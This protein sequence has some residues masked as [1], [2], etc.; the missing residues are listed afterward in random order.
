[1]PN[2]LTKEK[3]QSFEKGPIRRSLFDNGSV[4]LFYREKNRSCAS[5]C[6]YFLVGTKDE[7]KEEHGIVHFI[8]HMLFKEN[9]ADGLIDKLELAGASLN[10]YT[11]RE[12]VCFEMSCLAKRLDEF[13]PMFLELF[14]NPVFEKKAFETE[15][16]VILQEIKDEQDDHE[17][18]GYDKILNWHLD[19]KLGHSITGTLSSVKKITLDQMEKFY[20]KH[21]V[22]NKMI[23]SVVSGSEFSKLE[24]IFSSKQNQKKASR[25]QKPIRLK[26][27]NKVGKFTPFKK[28][29]KRKMENALYFLSF[30]GPSLSSQYFYDYLVLDDI[31]CEGLSSKYFKELREKR[32]LLYSYG[33]AINSFQNTGVYLQ[34]FSCQKDKVNSLK[35]SLASLLKSYSESSFSDEEVDFV[36]ARI[37]DHWQMEFDDIDDI[38]EFIA[39]KEIYGQTNFSLERQ[40]EKLDEV[41]KESLKA[42]LVKL[43]ATGPS[44][45]TYL[46]K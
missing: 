38:N 3:I 24:K 40:C 20:Q 6:L 43:L 18:L 30:D 46:P 42:L 36:K 44:E 28:Q 16:K 15:K 23:L 2:L 10:A 1:M 45:L 22:S 17:S 14:L 34:I 25:L 32:G 12:Y 11:Y 19:E 4:S 8:E 27:Q 33:S 13:L 7:K 9:K 5:V 37:K 39:E 41:S 21:F 26:L 35:K 31:L 29:S